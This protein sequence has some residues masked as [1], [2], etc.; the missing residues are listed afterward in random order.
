MLIGA[1]ETFIL[2]GS[3]MYRRFEGR[4]TFSNSFHFKMYMWTQLFLF[5]MQKENV[6][7]LNVCVVLYVCLCCANYENVVDRVLNCTHDNY[8]LTCTVTM[9]CFYMYIHNIYHLSCCHICIGM[10]IIIMSK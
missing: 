3:G 4:H 1:N 7:L 5:E 9:L 2:F 8:V 10:I 6:F